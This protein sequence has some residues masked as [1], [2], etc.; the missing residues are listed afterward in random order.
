MAVLRPYIDWTFFFTAWEM[1]GRYPQILNDP[2]RGEAARDLF[3][4]ANELL[5]DIEARELL[6]ARACSASGRR[7]PRTTTWSW[8]PTT[9]RS[10]FPM[11]RQQ[12]AFDD[13]R[14]NRSLADFV[15]PAEAGLH[16]HIGAFAVTAGIGAEELAHEFEAGQRRLPGDHGEGPGRPAGRGVRGA[17]A[18]R[19]AASVGLRGPRT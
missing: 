9:A 2:R 19:G 15:A 11:L 16:D 13:G 3:D 6:G 4:A 10:R 14:A 5:D 18:P 1:K 17:P 12:A 7:G 8:G